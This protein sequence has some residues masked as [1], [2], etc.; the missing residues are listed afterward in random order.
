M[1][2]TCATCREE[3]DLGKISF[4]AHAPTQWHLLDDEERARSEL[5]SDQCVL[6]SRDGRHFFVRACLEIPI[7]GTDRRFTWG[8]WV[9]LSEDNFLE[10]SDHWSDPERVHMG[11][12]FG[13]LCTSVPE[14]PDSMFLKTSV[15]QRPVGQRPVVELEPTDHPLALDQRRGIEL[16]DMEAIVGR[17]LH[18]PS[19]KPLQTDGASRRR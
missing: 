19:N 12:Y 17:L 14:Y 10:M 9:S 8:V 7:R 1:L 5:T 3:H 11:P 15:H 16:Q 13:W 4:G 6:E 18:G 2:F